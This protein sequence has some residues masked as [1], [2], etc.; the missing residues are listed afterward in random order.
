MLHY[1]IH[2]WNQHGEEVACDVTAKA[3]DDHV[4]A[5]ITLAFD[6][7]RLFPLFPDV[8]RWVPPAM[9][10]FFSA[11]SEDPSSEVEDGLLDSLRDAVDV[12]DL[13]VDASCSHCAGG[14]EGMYDGSR[15]SACGGS[16]EVRS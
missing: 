9:L 1:V 12:D 15:C 14:G 2:D 7:E 16:G 13:E 6:G 5:V 8:E 4:R 10:A 11:Y 3:H